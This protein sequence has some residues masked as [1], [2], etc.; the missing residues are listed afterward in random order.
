MIAVDL[1]YGRNR[2]ERR[3]MRDD[4]QAARLV[5]DE[6]ELREQQQRMEFLLTQKQL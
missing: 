3:L 5:Q 1:H 4:I 6:E 2:E